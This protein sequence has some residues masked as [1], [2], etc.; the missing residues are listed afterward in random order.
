M[1][2]LAD[3]GALADRAVEIEQA[4]INVGG[5]VV[6]NHDRGVVPLVIVGERAVRNVAAVDVGV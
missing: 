3:R 4:F 1:N 2:G 6:R 5:A